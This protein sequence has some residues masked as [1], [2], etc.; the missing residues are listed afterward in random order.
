VIIAEHHRPGHWL[1]KDTEYKPSCAWP[2]KCYVQWGSSG[3]VLSAEGNY[4]TSFFKAF[5]NN[6][7]GGFIRAEGSTI[8]EAEAAAFFK[9]RKEV[10]CNRRWGRKGY[11]NG[12][13]FCH[14]CGAFKTVFQ[15]V[16]ILGQWRK[17]LSRMEADSLSW[18]AP[19]PAADPD[20]RRSSYRHKLE[21]RRKVFDVESPG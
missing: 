14:H 16:H 1:A 12:G 11:L 21:L 17:P 7:S 10:A 20:C 6:N 3:V 9:Y 8:E 19:D 13:G 15:E 18:P 4:R 5:P 2:E